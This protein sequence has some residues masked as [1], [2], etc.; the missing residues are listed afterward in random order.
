MFKNFGLAVL[1]LVVIGSGAVLAEDGDL[2]FDLGAD[3]Y[4]KYIWRGINVNDDYVFQPSVNVTYESFTVGVWGN[5]DFTDYAGEQGEFSEIDYY[6]DYTCPMPGLEGVSLSVGVINYHFPSLVGDT[7]EVYWGLAFDMPLSP[8]VTVYHDIDEIDGTYVSFAVGHDFGTI[9][10]LT[11]DMPLGMDFS[12]S[13]GYGDTDY[14]KGYW[15]STEN[16]GLNDL[17]LS[18]SFPFEVSGVSVSPSLNYVSIMD[19]GI[20]SVDSAASDYFFTGISLS[21]SF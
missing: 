17:M 3:F 13:L 2:G 16:S 9:A 5:L 18:V 4:S 11:E 7:T 6:V 20:R 8:S 14:N 21:K 1:A 19:G 12:A 10:K 15:A